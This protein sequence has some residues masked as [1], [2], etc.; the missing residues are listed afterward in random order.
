MDTFCNAVV[1]YYL[2]KNILISLKV[3]SIIYF[4]SYHNINVF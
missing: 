2:I 1:G 3:P 4:Y